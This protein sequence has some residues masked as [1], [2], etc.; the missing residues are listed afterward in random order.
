MTKRTLSLPLETIE[1][2]KKFV[3]ILFPTR[4][5]FFVSGSRCSLVHVIG[6]RMCGIAGGVA[7]RPDARPN[8]E[9]IQRM[10]DLIA[11]RGPDGSG[12]WMSPDG[13]CI[14][15]HRRLSV[16]D[17]ETG[18]QPMRHSDDSIAVA[19]NGETYNYLEVREQLIREGHSFRTQS[20]TEVLLA[21]YAGRGLDFLEPLRGMF[22]IG[23][24]D[25]SRRQLVLAR[26]RIGKK[27]LYYT[28]EDGCLYFASTLEALHRTT[29]H[30]WTPASAAISAY[31][32]LGYV[33]APLTAYEQAF[34]LK[35]GAL[36]CA[37]PE[38]LLPARKY[39]V[40]P[41]SFEPF[42]GSFEDAC[43][44][45]TEMLTK[46]FECGFAVTCPSGFS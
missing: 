5:I 46:P 36:L 16:I 14:L 3:G 20:D 13:T 8:P 6:G 27:P 35:A 42:A 30:R 7:I 4:A 10:S 43:D 29:E 45:T 23:L 24:W 28:V 18:A 12:W 38:G 26:D 2:K 32:T 17:L 15:A 21:A 40:L 41:T 19:F 33:P 39:W 34:K 11:H 31:L 22:A 1:K 44:R 9:R 37:G 25:V